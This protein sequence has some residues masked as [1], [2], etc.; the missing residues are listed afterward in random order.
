L[1]G[2]VGDRAD[3]ATVGVVGAGTMGAGIA[4]V[5]AQGGFAT[6]VH[7]PVAATRGSLRGRIEDSLQRGAARGRWEA[8][9]ADAA[10]ARISIAERLE[11]L[12]GCDLIVEAAPESLDLKRAI[13]AELDAACPPETI[14]AT[15]TSSIAVGAIAAAVED[16]SR[17]IG[18]HFF[19]PVPL[20][21]LVEVIR[22][23]ASDSA[24]AAAA[25]RA[26]TA[27]GKAPIGARD[28]IGFVA[29]RCARPFTLEGLRV[30][31]ELGIAPAEVDR[32]CRLG[33]GFRMGPFELIDLVGADVSLDA[34]RSFF[35]QSFGE[36]R[37]RPHRTQVAMAQSGRLGRKSGRG[38]YVYGDGPHREEDPPI[39][40]PRPLLDPR[41]LAELAGPDAPRVLAWISAQIV[42]EA[43]FAL[44][45]GVASEADIDTAMRL[46]L[47]WPIGPLE[48]GRR[49]GHARVL[50]TLLELR[51]AYGDAYRPAPLIRELAASKD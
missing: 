33:G 22:A 8:E 9:A 5:A 27:M 40:E 45:E 13:F 41:R 28:S 2:T 18:L 48:W 14:L 24:A 50:E 32:I 23:D 31:A 37:W 44:A 21:R 17:V 47:N 26:V 11:D 42:N 16:P 30:S 12:A 20:M 7:D 39:D 51:D 1:S 38:F 10:L 36:P 34:A 3:I 4:Q 19:N 25:E 49:L 15:N 35:E 43:S 46:G 6:S 29:N